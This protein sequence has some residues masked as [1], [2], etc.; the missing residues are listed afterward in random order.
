MMRWGGM[1]SSRSVMA[2]PSSRAAARAMA[3]LVSCWVS[4]ATVVSATCDKR[5]RRLSSNPTTDMSPGTSM[6]ALRRT[7]RTPVAL[8]SLNTVT[9][10]G[11]GNVEQ[12]A[13][14]SG[15]IVLGE[16]AG[17][18]EG[19]I[20]KAVPLEGLAVAAAAFGAA[21]CAAAVDVGDAGVAEP[22]EV[23]DGLTQSGGVVDPDHVDGAV[24]HRPGDDD[25]GHAGCEFGQ[26]GRRCVG[27]EQ[28][29][30]P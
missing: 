15:S 30:R 4:C 19:G 7:S 11:R 29:K 8:R 26:G 13:S 10:V 27:A 6:P 18:D 23:V 1:T 20:G 5:A 21:G 3:R 12:G 24:P 28:D 2:E 25:E 16:T 14:R 22:D 17:Q 9:A